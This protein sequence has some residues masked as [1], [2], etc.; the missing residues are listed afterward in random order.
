MEHFTL[1]LSAFLG[2][3]AGFRVRDQTQVSILNFYR[4]RTFLARLTV[5]QNHLS[6]AKNKIQ[7][8][9]L[10]IVKTQY[11]ISLNN[12]NKLLA[13]YLQYYELG[14]YVYNPGKRY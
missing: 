14:S 1:L 8:V 11:E 2:F 13:I 12:I 6:P 3:T 4:S 10:A 9:P 7:G 5:T